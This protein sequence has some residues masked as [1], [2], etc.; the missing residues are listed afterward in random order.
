MINI[1]L[2]K[3]SNKIIEELINDENKLINTSTKINYW[4]DYFK[5]NLR[6]KIKEKLNV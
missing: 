3:E 1:T 2:W 6:K 4:W 5:S